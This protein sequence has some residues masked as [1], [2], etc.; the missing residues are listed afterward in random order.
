MPNLIPLLDHVVV[1]VHEGL[2]DA[3]SRYRRLGFQLT[4]RGHHSLGSSNH[5]AIF[6]TDYLELLG[7]EAG[8]ATTGRAD[9][10]AEPAGL[11]GLV[12]KSADSTGLH[13]EILARGLE[14]EG[15]PR[16]FTRPVELP[17]ATG[18]ARFRTVRLAAHLVPNGRLYFCHHFTPEL[19]WRGHWQ[20]HPNGVTGVAQ[21]VIAAADPARTIGLLSRLFGAEHVGKGA[22]GELLRAGGASVVVLTPEAAARRFG[23]SVPPLIDG[24]DRMVALVLRTTALATARAALAAGEIRGVEEID[25][26]LVVPP[27]EAA[28][29]TLAFTE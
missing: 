5:L 1:N 11:T 16:E 6:D 8:K 13:R 18:E 23:A 12:F 24:R 19:V 28:G 9:L 21:Y 22:H 2:D 14:V 10:L 4:P 25:G 29:V 3:A 20:V 17:G 26:L 15:P 27:A 7:F